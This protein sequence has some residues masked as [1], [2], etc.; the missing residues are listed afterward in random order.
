MNAYRLGS[1]LL[2]YCT[3]CFGDCSDISRDNID[4]KLNQAHFYL[5]KIFQAPA[6]EAEVCYLAEMAQQ[7][8]FEAQF[9]LNKKDD[10]DRPR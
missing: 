6:N 4:E 5:E 9:L 7:R 10:L 8:I 3:T 2:V 1:C